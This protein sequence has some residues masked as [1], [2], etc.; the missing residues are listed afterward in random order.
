MTFNDIT[1]FASH[2]KMP[3]WCW[4]EAGLFDSSTL[5]VYTS[6]QCVPRFSLPQHGIVYFVD[7]V[8]GTKNVIGS[9]KIANC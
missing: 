2:F 7:L 8:T 5:Y 4:T 1:S 3:K 9:C 6:K